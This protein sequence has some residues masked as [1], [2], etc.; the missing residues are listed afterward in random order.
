MKAGSLAP[1][2]NMTSST[3]PEPSSGE[4]TEFVAELLE[5]TGSL[6]LIVDHLAR[7]DLHAAAPDGEPVPDL[8]GRLLGAVL[9]PLV[10]WHGPGALR[11][12]AAVL[13]DA[14]ELACAAV[15]TPGGGALG[16]RADPLTPTRRRR[17]R[18]TP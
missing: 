16:P 1:L 8:L 5:A 10:A 15:F 9:G 2:T 6:M 11:E 12:A 4:L 17:A 13:A 7:F 18:R 14:R 3:N